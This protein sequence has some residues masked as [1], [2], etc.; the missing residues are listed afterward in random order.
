MRLVRDATC[1]A[2]LPLVT[3]MFL[4]GLLGAVFR[5]VLERSDRFRDAVIDWAHGKEIYGFALLI[6]FSAIATGFAYWLVRKFWRGGKGIGNP[7]GRGGPRAEGKLTRRKTWFGH[8]R[9]G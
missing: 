2:T 7:D 5:L 3:R 1:S 8:T 6:G 9:K 4:L